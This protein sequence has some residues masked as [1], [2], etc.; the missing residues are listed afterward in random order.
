MTALSY[1]Q[2]TRLLDAYQKAINDGADRSYAR[3]WACRQTGTRYEDAK[4]VIEAY[5]DILAG[6]DSA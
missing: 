1:A 3:V 2:E 5:L 4:P 6:D